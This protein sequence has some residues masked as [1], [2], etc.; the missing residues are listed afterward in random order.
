MELLGTKYSLQRTDVP[1]LLTMASYD[2][3]AFVEELVL[4]DWTPEPP[5]CLRRFSTEIIKSV[6]AA[7][8]GGAGGL[9]ERYLVWF[10]REGAGRDE[11]FR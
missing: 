6:E 1:S 9:S 8:G 11:R 3:L 4:G 7:G 10:I 5:Q 2:N